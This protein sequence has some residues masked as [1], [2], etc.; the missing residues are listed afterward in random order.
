MTTFQE[1]KKKSK[2]IDENESTLNVA[3]L[4]DTVTQILAVALKGTAREMGYNLDLFEA[5]YNQIE[6]QILDPTSDLYNHK[7]QYTIVFHS[8]HK[9]LEQY[10]LKR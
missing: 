5:E 6:R 9:L 2:T 7:P 10:C 3:L 1:L 8:T 4:S